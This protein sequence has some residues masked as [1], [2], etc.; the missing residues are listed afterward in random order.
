MITY[1]IYEVVRE[2]PKIYS[3]VENYKPYYRTND[4][5]TNLNQITKIVSYKENE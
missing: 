2:Y 1:W 5:S 3:Y 4:C